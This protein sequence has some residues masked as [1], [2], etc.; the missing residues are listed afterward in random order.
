MAISCIRFLLPLPLSSLSFSL[1][2]S[3]SL[4][5][6]H[7]LSLTHYLCIAR[8]LTLSQQFYLSQ[9]I[10]IYF[11]RNARVWKMKFPPEQFSDTLIL[12]ITLATQLLC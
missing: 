10:L 9:F 4:S 1:S 5:V 11:R 3:L 12:L 2:L 6:M 8:S 7:A